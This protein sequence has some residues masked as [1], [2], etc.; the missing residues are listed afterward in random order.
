MKRL[1]WNR[2]AKL[3]LKHAAGWL[4]IVLGLVMLVTPGQGILSI[5]VGVYLLADEVPMFGRLKARLQRRFP[6]ATDYVHTKGEK[7]K[8][9]FHKEPKP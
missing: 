2:H 8:A 9:R 7:L 6:K 1:I 5:L 4:C 3:L